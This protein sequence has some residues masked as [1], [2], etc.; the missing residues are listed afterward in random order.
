[1]YPASAPPK[2]PARSSFHFFAAVAFGYRKSG[3]A[4]NQGR[5]IFFFVIVADDEFFFGFFLRRGEQLR[6]MAEEFG[7]FFYRPRRR[8]G[9][10][11]FVLTGNQTV[12]LAVG[13]GKFVFVQNG[14]EQGRG[15]RHALR[16]ELLGRGASAKSACGE[17]SCLVQGA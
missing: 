13:V 12:Q 5:R 8:F 7:F 6:I 16:Q 1:M 17:L 14:V 4:L 2:S 15:L 3:N 11:T 9:V 10:E